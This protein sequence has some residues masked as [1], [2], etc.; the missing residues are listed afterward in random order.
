MKAA[1]GAAIGLVV[2]GATLG[3]TAGSST[4][5]GFEPGSVTA[6]SGQEFWVLGT[7]P[8]RSGRCTAVV[9]SSDGGRSFARI[10]A[11]PLP[12]DAGQA[13]GEMY[14]A[15]RLDGFAFAPSH[16][17]SFWTTHNGGTRWH[18]VALR[19]VLAFATGGGWPMR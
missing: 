5:A 9:Y 14:F 18:R 3:A 15:D 6:V 7:A 10:S 2:L 16:A 11:P 19:G 17:R 8:C 13:L 12:V 1:L 4:K